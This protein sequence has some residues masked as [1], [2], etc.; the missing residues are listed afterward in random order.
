MRLTNLAASL[1]TIALLGA[2]ATVENQTVHTESVLKVPA[3]AETGAVASGD[4]AADDPAIWVLP[5]GDAVILGTDKRDGGGLYVYDAN[6]NVRQRLQFGPLNNVDVRPHPRSD[7]TAIVVASHRRASLVEIFQLDS[8]GNLSHLQSFPVGLPDPYGICLGSAPGEAFHVGVTSTDDGFERHLIVLGKD[9]FFE[10]TL[11]QSLIFGAQAEGCVFD[12]RRDVFYI[13]VEEVGIF[14]YDT[15]RTDQSEGETLALVD[16]VQLFADV[17]GLTIWERGETGGY[18][19]ASSQANDSFTVYNLPDESF[20]GRFTVVSN[21]DESVDFVTHTDGV[22]ASSTPAKG[23][24]HGLIVVQ[25][26][27]NTTP[28]GTI[29]TQNFKIVDAAFLDQAF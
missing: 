4:D 13:G 27:Q 26:D 21:S 28:D 15:A 5:N 7:G 16:N 8:Q 20:A 6:G 29:T 22:D 14:K 9:D 19:I 18:L 3:F 25:D 17:E 24:P 10:S 23:F 2:C 11:Q 12:D 1:S